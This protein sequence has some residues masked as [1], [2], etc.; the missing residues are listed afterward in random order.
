MTTHRASNLPCLYLDSVASPHVHIL[1]NPFQYSLLSWVSLLLP[2]SIGNIHS[3][4]PCAHLKAVRHQITRRIRINRESK[5]RPRDIWGTGL[6][7][8]HQDASH[9][10]PGVAR[11]LEESRGQ[12]A[13]GCDSGTETRAFPAGDP[14]SLHLI[15]CPSGQ[16]F[17][18][19]EKKKNSVWSK[20][21]TTPKEGSIVFSL[22]SHGCDQCS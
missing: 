14:S 18:H 22:M 13:A 20:L 10:W 5:T 16:V 1:S 6:Y 11:A 19:G 21:W 17:F 3:Y 12:G 15:L 4:F 9:I 7:L 2:C 8:A